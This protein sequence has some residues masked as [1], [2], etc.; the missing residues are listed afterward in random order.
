MI[1]SAL[2]LKKLYENY[3]NQIKFKSTNLMQLLTTKKL[4]GIAKQDSERSRSVTE[5]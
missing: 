4:G 3:N 5:A 2:K 1:N